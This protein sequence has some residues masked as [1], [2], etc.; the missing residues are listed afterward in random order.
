MAIDTSLKADVTA[1][2]GSTGS[3]KGS[4]MKWILNREKFQRLAI[5]DPE[6][7]YAE[8]GRVVRSS[9]AMLAEIRKSSFR[10]VFVPLDDAEIKIAQFDAFSQQLIYQRLPRGVGME[11]VK[12]YFRI[13]RCRSLGH[14]FHRGLR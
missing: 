4:R 8:Y 9:R 2:I 10:V 11:W 5:W 7:E 13:Q 3:G 14:C 6:E 1:I 12:R